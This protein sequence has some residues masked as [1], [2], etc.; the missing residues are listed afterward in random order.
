MT[1]IDERVCRFQNQYVVEMRKGEL[2]HTN[3]KPIRSNDTMGMFPSGMTLRLLTTSQK[4][5][6]KEKELVA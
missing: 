4:D 6:G 2:R 5:T 1:P 3:G